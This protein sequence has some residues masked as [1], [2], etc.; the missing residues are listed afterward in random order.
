MSD[1]KN[2]LESILFAAGKA[3]KLE[4]LSRL[5]KERDLD[6]VK[7]ALDEL[8]HELEQKQGSVM[9]MNDCDE[10]KLTVRE[11]YLPF[12]RKIV[13][14]TEPPKSIIETLA[15]VAFKAPVLQS[16]VIQ[17]RTNKAYQH[18]DFL[19]EKGY[20]TREKKGRTKLIKLTQKF[21]EYFDVPPEKL[22][23]KFKDFKELDTAIEQMEAPAEVDLLDEEGHKVKLEE[24]NAEPELEHYKETP[25]PVEEYA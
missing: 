3:I 15:I 10:W 11:K 5:T 9:L 2:R 8:R 4:E 24:Y 16:K 25:S 1:L 12:V 23:E 20:I 6:V 14:K 17:I 21:F 13:T 18:L 19:E 22:K 7:K